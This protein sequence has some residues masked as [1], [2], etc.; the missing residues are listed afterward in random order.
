MKKYINTFGPLNF[1]LQGKDY[2]T[3]K[4]DPLELPSDDEYVQTLVARGY[5]Q[6]QTEDVKPSKTKK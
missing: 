3:D 2:I 1:S 4:G 6:E 5:I